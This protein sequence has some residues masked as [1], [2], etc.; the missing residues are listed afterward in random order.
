[1]KRFL[2]VLILCA[3]W[4]TITAGAQSIYEPYFFGTYAGLAGETGSDDGMGSVA[5][6]YDPYGVAV[7]S[8]G[9]VYV[10]DCSNCIIRKITPDDIVR[11]LAGPGGGCGSDDGNGRGA[12][13]Y[14]PRG[15][16]GGSGR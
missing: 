14:V 3:M 8:A 5:R 1:M 2:I 15:V 13:L 9:N 7:D 16:A 10:A 11:T 4:G 12:P 6:F